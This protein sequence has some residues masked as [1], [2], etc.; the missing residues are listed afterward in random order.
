[1][2][3]AGPVPLS[4]AVL[5]RQGWFWLGVCLVVILACCTGNVVLGRA[6]W[7]QRAGVCLADSS[8][9]AC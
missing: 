5:T 6:L 3:S 7:D 9:A 2:P 1:M 8:G 4:G